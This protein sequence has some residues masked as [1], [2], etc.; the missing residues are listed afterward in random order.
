MTEYSTQ[1]ILNTQPINYIRSSGETVQLYPK[2]TLERS[3][4]NFYQFYGVS[5]SR[6]FESGL[7][8]KAGLIYNRSVGDNSIMAESIRNNPNSFYFTNRS[9]NE[10]LVAEVGLQVRFKPWKRIMGFMGLSAFKTFGGK[11]E[12]ER[13]AFQPGIGFEELEFKSLSRYGWNQGFYGLFTES[14]LQ[15]RLTKEISLGPMYYVIF[16]P[17]APLQLGY[18][19]EVRYWW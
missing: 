11:S 7:G 16:I 15:Y 4:R 17:N 5:V 18:G 1:A 2:E 12:T 6:Y 8:V 3:S 14:S 9:K 13:I 10:S 19:F